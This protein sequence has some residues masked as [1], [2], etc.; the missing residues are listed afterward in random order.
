MLADELASVDIFAGL[1]WPKMTTPDPDPFT[2]K[3][4]QRIEAWFREQRFAVRPRPGTY[5]VRRVAHPPYH[6]YVHTLFWTGLRPSEA[7]GLQAQDLE[8]GDPLP[9]VGSKH[10]GSSPRDA[11]STSPSRRVAV[12]VK[13]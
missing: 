12:P 10:A 1:R 3:E 5:G 8:L 9:C 6:A 13:R 11:T 7:S 4:V 2:I